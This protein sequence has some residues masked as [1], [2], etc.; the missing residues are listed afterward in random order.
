M[1]EREAKAE[2]GKKEGIRKETEAE[3]KRRKGGN[4]GLGHKLSV[5]GS[6]LE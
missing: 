6:L 4:I 5:A 1:K 2:G 3:R